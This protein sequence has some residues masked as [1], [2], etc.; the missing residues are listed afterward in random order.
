V[1]WLRFKGSAHSIFRLFSSRNSGHPNTAINTET[2]SHTIKQ[3]LATGDEE[4]F[5]Y[6]PP[7]FC[8]VV[9]C[10]KPQQS[11]QLKRN[12]THYRIIKWGYKILGIFAKRPRWKAQNWRNVAS[13]TKL[14]CWL[15]EDDQVPPLTSE[16]CANF[17]KGLT[18]QWWS[19]MARGPIGY[20][21]YVNRLHR[22]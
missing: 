1:A 2:Y 3:F 14:R 10:Q 4:I 22:F 18:V 9:Q 7:L 19:L 5:L 11:A 16:I 12:K 8:T 21:L 6:S 17:L 13:R 20:L 15:R